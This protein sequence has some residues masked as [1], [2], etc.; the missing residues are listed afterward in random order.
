MKDWLLVG[1]PIIS[2]LATLVVAVLTLFNVLIAR[3]SLNLL[4]AKEARWSSNFYLYHSDSYM[5]CFPSKDIRIYA[6]ALK[7]SNRSDA[8][9]TIV[10]LSLFIR[11][12]RG[13]A[14]STN[15]ELPQVDGNSNGT[16][17]LAGRKPEEILPRPL[18]LR[19][20]GAQQG[21]ALFQVEDTLLRSATIEVSEVRAADVHGQQV[22]LPITILRR[23]HDES[24]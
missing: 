15:L 20:H 10:D 2:S 4:E 23:E 18:F 24:I 13:S 16:T 22:S 14:C 19:A 9:N 6:I 3:R 1:V 17:L 5:K 21:W 7:V 12:N 11:F 8:D